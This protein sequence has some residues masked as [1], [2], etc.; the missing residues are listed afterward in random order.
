MNDVRR[1]Y[2]RLRVAV[3]TQGEQV[4]PRKVA[5]TS[6]LLYVFTTRSRGRLLCFLSDLLRTYDV[7]VL[8]CP[9]RMKEEEAERR[10]DFLHNMHEPSIFSHYDVHA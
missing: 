5:I 8:V 6:Q 4:L 1:M 7:S 2:V 10:L 3:A 9:L